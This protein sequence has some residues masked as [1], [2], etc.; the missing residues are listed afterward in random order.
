[1]GSIMPLVLYVI[2]L[3]TV[4][5]GRLWHPDETDSPCSDCV[6]RVEAKKEDSAS[7]RGFAP[8]FSAIFRKD[9]L[10]CPPQPPYNPRCTCQ[11]SADRV[12]TC[13]RSV[14]E[15]QQKQYHKVRV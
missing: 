14:W 11:E 12:T 9:V 13:S 4:N 6:C 3:S 10:S 7:N 8:W 1:M 15:L 2:A 5:N